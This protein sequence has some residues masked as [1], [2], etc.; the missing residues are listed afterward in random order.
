MYLCYVDESGDSG[1]VGSP[2]SHF[3]LSALLVHESKWLATLD[4]LRDF[5]RHLKS[6][7]GLK[8][9]EEIHAAAFIT[10]PGD[11]VRI[12]KWHRL[13]ILREV[14][15]FQASLDHV[16]VVNVVADKVT[17]AAG[18]ELFLQAWQRLIQRVHNA[19]TQ[20]PLPQGHPENA[21]LFIDASDEPALRTLV[22]KMRR[23]NPV[24]NKGRPGYRQV[25]VTSI[26]EDPVH[27]DSNHA[28][29]IQLADVNAYFLYQSFHPNAYIRK[30]TAH[31]FIRRLDPI[32]PR[33]AAPLHPLGI[34]VF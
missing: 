17:R 16:R 9:G 18:D 2:S 7:Y 12:P 11:L 32:L 1:L 30:R 4:A 6:K 25:L 20:G 28:H 13:M 31:T 10:R 24:P 33:S 21:M 29:F 23:Y 26:L 34:H 14:L 22:R 8:M 19:V 27:R 3:A 5:R 15:D